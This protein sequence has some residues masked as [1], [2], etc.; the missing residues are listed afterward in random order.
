MIE[1]KL[2]IINE[3][4]LSGNYFIRTLFVMLLISCQANYNDR[5]VLFK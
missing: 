5:E 3:E 2:I 4:A 1:I